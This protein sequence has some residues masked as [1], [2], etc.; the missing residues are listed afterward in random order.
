MTAVPTDRRSRG[1]RR[2]L[3]GLAAAGVAGLV[4]MSLWSAC[5]E[6]PATPVASPLGHS[7]QAM[8]TADGTVPRPSPVVDATD[9]CIERFLA[10]ASDP[11]Q[12]EEVTPQARATLGAAMLWLGTP[13]AWGGG[14]L[15]GP[16]HGTDEGGSVVG[17]DCSGLTRYAWASG[18]VLLPRNSRAQWGAPGTRVETM[19][20]LQPGDL[21]FFARDPADL[22][23]I[24]HVGLALGGDAM[25]EAPEPGGVVRVL[26]GLSTHLERAPLFVGGLRPTP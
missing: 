5:A 3:G 16:T 18:G 11:S 4:A 10:P 13:Y 6:R 15:Y 8:A 7:P 12:C 19:A 25:L 24:F 22:S 14:D 1:G 21:V 26:P 23:T 9:P 20:D 17:F 2:R